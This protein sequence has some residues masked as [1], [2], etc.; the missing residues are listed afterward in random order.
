MWMLVGVV[1]SALAGTWLALDKFILEKKLRIGDSITINRAKLAPDLPTQFAITEAESNINALI[2]A[3]PATLV[4]VKG[5]S[6]TA[7]PSGT[8]WRGLFG[9]GAPVVFNE[10]DVV[11]ILRGGKIIER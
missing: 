1:S 5:I 7:E 9:P 10:K 2:A 6:K 8:T 11:T 3:S 4:E